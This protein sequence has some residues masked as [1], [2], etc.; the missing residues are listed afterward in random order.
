M[1]IPSRREQ[2]DIDNLASVSATQMKLAFMKAATNA[3]ICWT[4][5]VE[6]IKESEHQD[7][8]TVWNQFKGSDQA[9]EDLQRYIKVSQGWHKLEMSDTGH[10]WKETEEGE[11]PNIEITVTCSECKETY[12]GKNERDLGSHEHVDQ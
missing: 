8:Y 12:S 2:E 10:F 5:V 7:G 3:H 6:Y 4:V 1:T 9:L 11:P